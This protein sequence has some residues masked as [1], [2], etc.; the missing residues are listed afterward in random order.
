LEYRIKSQMRA[1]SSS[2]SALHYRDKCF[3]SHINI[4]QNKDGSPKQP[5]SEQEK[6]IEKLKELMSIQPASSW[7]DEISY[8]YKH[9]SNTAVRQEEAEMEFETKHFKVV[10]FFTY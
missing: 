3:H 4:N 6:K 10:Y 8:F 7:F 5:K 1:H 9:E 2:E